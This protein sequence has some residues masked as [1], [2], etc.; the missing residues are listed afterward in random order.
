MYLNILNY[1]YTPTEKTSLSNQHPT[2]APHPLPPLQLHLS[3]WHCSY[4]S[5]VP[6]DLT[7]TLSEAQTSFLLYLTTPV[8]LQSEHLRDTVV[9]INIHFLHKNVICTS[10]ENLPGIETHAMGWGLFVG[11]FVCFVVWRNIHVYAYIHYGCKDS[12]EL[13]Q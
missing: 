2:Q 8:S 9:M 3:N 1:Y 11:L 13:E 4:S 10:T 7:L 5:S 12:Q 6:P